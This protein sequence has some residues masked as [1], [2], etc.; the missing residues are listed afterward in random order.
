MSQYNSNK[1]RYN[2]RNRY[3]N[4]G[5]YQQRYNDGRPNNNYYHNKNRPQNQNGGFNP[6][7]QNQ[8]NYQNTNKPDNNDVIGFISPNQFV[9][10]N[11]S[12]NTNNNPQHTNMYNNNNPDTT[13]EP[14]KRCPSCLGKNFK[15]FSEIVSHL[16]KIH[17][18]NSL[19]KDNIDENTGQCKLCHEQLD[20]DVEIYIQHLF[21]QH[22]TELAGS[23]QQSTSLKRW[24]KSIKNF[25]R[26]ILTVN[27][28]HHDV[29]KKDIQE[30]EDDVGKKNIQEEEDDDDDYANFIASSIKSKGIVSNEKVSINNIVSLNTKNEISK[31]DEIG[32]EFWEELNRIDQEMLKKKMIEATNHIFSCQ[33]CNKTFDSHI[34]LLRHCWDK[35]RDGA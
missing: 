14:E 13:P 34:K 28:P 31:S 4:G 24:E 21:D 26:V 27:E 8:Y 15:S 19:W 35:H 5:S 17:H 18:A 16:V 30:E 32:P 22:R 3:N 33:L 29:G 1:Q 10:S 7:K 11:F 2:Q 20:K 9:S 25:A 6:Q 23:I 12:N